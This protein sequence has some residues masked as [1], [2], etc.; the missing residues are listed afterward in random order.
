MFPFISLLSIWVCHVITF[1]S[2]TKQIY[3]YIVQESFV[4]TSTPCTT[5]FNSPPYVFKMS[6]PYGL[7]T[8]V[9]RT[10]Q[11]NESRFSEVRVATF[12][13]VAARQKRQPSHAASILT[14]NL[15]TA[16]QNGSLSAKTSNKGPVETVQGPKVVEFLWRALFGSIS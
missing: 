16:P 15:S 9:S 1:I 4:P 11:R 8:Q 6:D 7:G 12:A 14:T 5:I 13:S 10:W 3:S 2:P